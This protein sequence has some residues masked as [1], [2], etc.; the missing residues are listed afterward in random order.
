MEQVALAYVANSPMRAHAVC[1]ARNG[2]EAM[3]NMEAVTMKL[4]SEERRWLELGDRHHE[5]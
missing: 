3:A 4:T 2:A 1:A 5:D